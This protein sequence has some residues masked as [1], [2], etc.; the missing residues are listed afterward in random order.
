MQKSDHEVLVFDTNKNKAYCLNETSA[1]VWQLCNGNNTVSEL[2]SKMSRQLNEIVSEDL[3]WM[4]LD[5][6]KKEG[7]LEESDLDGNPH[8]GLS[9]RDV[10]RK[11]GFVSVVALPVISSILAPTAIQA[12]SI[13]CSCEAPGDCL[14]RVGC[15]STVNCN[16][17]L[18]CA[19]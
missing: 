11:V 4:A 5:Q 19:P 10:I 7:L 15:P 6:F 8:F 18:T 1:L 13:N 12:Q 17:A 16:G 3:A 9:R 14:V 2:T